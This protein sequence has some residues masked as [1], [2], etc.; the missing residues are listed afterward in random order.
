MATREV[1]DEEGRLFVNARVRIPA[2]EL[3]IRATKSGGPGGQHVNTSST[4]VE[5]VW[6]MRSSIALT[7]EQRAYL[8]QRLASKLDA[9][10]A[11][12]VVATDT[13]SQTQN[14]A[15][16]LYR[17]ANTVRDALV[18]PKPRRATA[19]SRGQ[20]QQRLDEKKRR[21]HVKRD[22]R[23]HDDDCVRCGGGES[24]ARYL[25][26]LPPKRSVTPSVTV[27]RSARVS[28]GERMTSPV[29][30]SSDTS[31]GRR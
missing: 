28:R 12:R 19:P 6:V 29:T 10:G 24:R 7:D 18:V 22:R 11:L 15:L 26:P 31:P 3:S 1:W 5:V 20:R 8:E 9:S 27:S 30:G 16:A 25:F 2:S 17:L 14:R 13:R 21:S 4:R 23:R